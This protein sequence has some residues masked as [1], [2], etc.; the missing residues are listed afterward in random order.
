MH[1]VGIIGT[2]SYVPEK[3]LTNYDLEKMV[4]TSDKWIMERTGIRERRIAG[5]DETNVT[6]GQL[7]L[8]RAIENARS[9]STEI[10]ML[11]VVPIPLNRFGP[12]LRVTSRVFSVFAKTYLSLI[13]RQGVPVSIILWPWQNNL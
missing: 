6:M 9:D 11:V 3:V 1:H 13:C 12:L 5:E 7:A 4:Q 2:G 8:E 10:E